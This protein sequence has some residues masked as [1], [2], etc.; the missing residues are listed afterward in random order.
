MKITF[1]I[2]SVLLIIVSAIQIVIGA[3]LIIDTDKFFEIASKSGIATGE[4][5]AAGMI[6]SLIGV[7]I[8]A[9]G[10]FQLLTGINGMR[11]RIEKCRKCT[12]WI[13]II[14]AGNF[15]LALV[16]HLNTTSAVL[17]LLFFG[18]YYLLAKMYMKYD[19]MY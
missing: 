11:G 2:F 18:I 10:A 5:G 7:I 12:F 8:I 16:K 9:F 6:I 14:T 13:L 4:L 1:K 19:N 17:W 3:L 15:I